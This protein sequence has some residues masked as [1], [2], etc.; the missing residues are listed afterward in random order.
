MSILSHGLDR[1]C[2][3]AEQPAR[4]SAAR[5]AQLRRIAA[6]A[7]TVLPMGSVLTGLIALKTVIYVWHLRA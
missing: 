5:K 4:L 6:R 1:S 3:G 2:D 7:L